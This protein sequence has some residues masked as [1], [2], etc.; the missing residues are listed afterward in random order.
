MITQAGPKR[1]RDETFTRALVDAGLLIP[2]GALGVFS[3]SQSFERV[4]TAVDRL[5]AAAALAQ[6]AVE[7]FQPPVMARDVLRR[8]G[9]MER[10]PQFCGSIHSFSGDEAAHTQLLEAVNEQ[11]DWSPQLEQSELVL[12]PAACYA[13]YPTIK[14]RIATSGLRV[15]LMSYVFRREPSQDPARRQIF[16][17]REDVQIGSAELIMA[18]RARW[19]TQSLE[20]LGGLGLDLVMEVATDPFFGRAG[21]FYGHT[22]R[23]QELKLEILAPIA[24]PET[25]TAI[26]SLNYH[27]EQIATTFGL[28]LES[29]AVAHSGCFA[30]G[31]ERVA[32]ALFRKHGFEVEG[33]PGDVRRCLELS[34]LSRAH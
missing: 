24:D 15:S 26:A 13:L 31:L 3:H 17:M 18:W 32:L 33:W 7:R 11:R 30:V 1:T 27:R 20:L 8:A 34:K 2:A 14:G 4:V 23:G 10:F 12:C 6:G 22:Q 9:Y 29:G 16:R 19:R 25:P 5:V 21:R 28:E